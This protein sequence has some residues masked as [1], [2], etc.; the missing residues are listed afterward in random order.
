MISEV[1][2][3]ISKISKLIFNFFK[4]IFTV[5]FDH[6]NVALVSIRNFFSKTKTNVTDSN[7]SVY[8][9]IHYFSYI[10]RCHY[11]I[12]NPFFLKGT[13]IV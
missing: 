6:I 12:Y 8:I 13:A 1:L 10:I 11:D 2:F 4:I 7:A 3:Q 9:N 5:F